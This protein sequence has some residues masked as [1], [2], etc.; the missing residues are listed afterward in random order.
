MDLIQVNQNG[1]NYFRIIIKKNVISLKD[2]TNM[3]KENMVFFQ[4]V[5]SVIIFTANEYNYLDLPVGLCINTDFTRLLKQI[6]D[7]EF[8]AEQNEAQ[9]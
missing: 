6:T 4:G 3:F 8:A 5:G 2:I 7:N 9:S 1:K